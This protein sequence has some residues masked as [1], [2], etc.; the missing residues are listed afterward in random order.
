M[1]K[2]WNGN[3]FVWLPAISTDPNGG[4]TYGVLPVLVLSDPETHHIRQLLAPSYTYNKLFGQTGTMRYYW[5]PSESSQYVTIG[6][7]SQHT[8]R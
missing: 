2:S 8:N 1:T 3:I 4:P 7:F 5:Y 6:S